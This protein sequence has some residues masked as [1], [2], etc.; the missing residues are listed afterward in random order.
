MTRTPKPHEPAARRDVDA[1]TPHRPR[2]IAPMNDPD[3][4]VAALTYELIRAAQGHTLRVRT[5]DGRDVLLRLATVD[6]ALDSQ[7]RALDG[8]RASGHAVP[9]A[10][11]RERAAELVRPI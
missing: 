6:E 1:P 7:R 3:M 2:I 4:V 11:S 9:E 5:L 8:Y 10:M